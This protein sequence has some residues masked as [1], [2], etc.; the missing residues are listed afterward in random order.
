LGELI[1]RQRSRPPLGPSQFITQYDLSLITLFARNLNVSKGSP[2]DVAQ[3][4]LFI[5]LIEQ[6]PITVQHMEAGHF[7]GSLIHSTLERY[8]GGVP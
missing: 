5:H 1:S 3:T 4:P 6:G 8:C 7:Q 2:A